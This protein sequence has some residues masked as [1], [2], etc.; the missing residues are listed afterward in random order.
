MPRWSPGATERGEDTVVLLTFDS[1]ADLNRWLDSAP[2]RR[3]LQAMEALAEGLR[4]VSVV[5]GFAG[6]FHPVGPSPT[7]RWKQ[8]TVVCIGLV[9]LACAVTLVRGAVPPSL[10]PVWG[11]VLSTVVNVGIV[12]W[13]VMP[14]LTRLLGQW[15]AR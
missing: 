10:P 12:T 2:R 7:K 8:A 1:R 15:L 13:G 3:I 5:G 9:P 11:S 4:T 14:W 6:W